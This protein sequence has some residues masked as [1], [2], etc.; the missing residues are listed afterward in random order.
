MLARY[1]ARDAVEKRT[2]SDPRFA[3]VDRAIGDNG[4]KIVFLLRLSPVF[5]FSF[6]NYALG[7]TQVSIRDYAMGSFGMLPATLLY[8]YY[9]KVIGDA[10]ALRAFRWERVGD[11][12]FL[13]ALRRRGFEG[14]ERR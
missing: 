12:L 13:V 4:L 10:A 9:G 7:L 1:V 6:G 8:V 3:T 14:E 5:P 2:A 11:A